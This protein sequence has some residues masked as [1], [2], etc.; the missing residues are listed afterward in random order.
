MNISTG[1]HRGKSLKTLLVNEPSYF[2]WLLELDNPYGEFCE[3]Q[4]YAK[5]LIEQFDQ[6]P[7]VAACHGRDCTTLATRCSVYRDNFQSLQWWCDVCSPYGHGAAHGTLGIVATYMDAV[8]YVKLV[9]NG[10][11]SD[12]KHLVRALAKAKG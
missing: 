8:L 5:A 9:C 11:K 10:R 4:P 2:W 12:L 6:L 1:K 7:F 3:L